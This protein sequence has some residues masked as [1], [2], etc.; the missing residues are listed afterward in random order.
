MGARG[1]LAVL[2]CVGGACVRHPLPATVGGGEVAAAA[3]SCPVG[4][5]PPPRVWRLT[6]AQLRNTL[7]DV[8]GFAGPAV[9]ALPPDSRIDGFANGAD[10][11]G[12]PSLLLEYYYK[13]ADEVSTEVVRRSGELLAC[14]VSALA[15]G[16]C[17]DAFL[18]TVGLRAWRRPLSPA[19]RASLAR[20]FTTAAAA[21]GPE[22]GLKSLVEALIVSPSFIYRFELGAGGGTTVQLTDHELASALS[23]TLWD[24][25]P[26]PILYQLAAA[27]RLHDP[28][29]LHAQAQRLFAST[30]RASS[31]LTS[32]LRQWL[33]VDDLPAAGKDPMLFPMYD[34]MMARDLLEE[35]HLFVDGVVFDAAGDRSLRT[36]LTAGYG[37]LNSKTAKIYGVQRKGGELVRT[38]LDRGQRRGLLTQ[39]AFLAAHADADTTRVVDRGKFVREEVL[40]FEVPPPPDDFKFDET[41]ITE[42]MTG[43]EKLSAHAKNPFCA[44]CH[45]LFDGIGFA[46]ENYDAV[47]RFRTTDKDK[48]IDPT[49][50]LPL[51]G[52]EPLHFA[53]F[54]D[55]VDQIAGLPEPYDCFASRYLGYATGRAAG[56]TC[57]RDKVLRAFRASGYRLD[58]LVMAVIDSP[59]FVARR[60]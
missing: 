57:E 15:P 48:P 14:P 59:G 52:R 8:F 2:A 27:G 34:R 16:P 41:K 3:P 5:L 45:A 51:P 49:G 12:V 21:A 46:L 7:L 28:A 19:E 17:L 9:D 50:A 37:Y 32:F 56:G 24:A 33:R 53:S 29:T 31:A 10:R 42:D 25:P 1:W 54:V 4:E 43:R 58:V 26:D 18:A 60:R 35:T 47:G 36:L 22:M 44:S 39:A 38:E 40:C 23:Y 30:K 55:L 6:H 20:V 13:A 11:L